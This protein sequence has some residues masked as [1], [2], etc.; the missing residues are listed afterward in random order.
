MTAFRSSSYGQHYHQ[1]DQLLPGDM[2]EAWVYDRI[3]LVSDLIQGVCL[4]VSAHP[5]QR[6][7]IVLRRSGRVDEVWL[8]EGYRLAIMSRPSAPA[9]VR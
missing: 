8:D 1:V 7:V 5:R 9:P 4:S 6:H 2:F 3:S